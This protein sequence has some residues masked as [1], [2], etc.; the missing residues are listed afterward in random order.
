ML[1]HGTSCWAL[2]LTVEKVVIDF[3]FKN[4][5]KEMHVG[6]LRSTIISDNIAYMLEYCNVTM[7]QHNHV[8]N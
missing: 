2:V 6:H 1:K 7:L 5:V 8:G 3:F 4:I